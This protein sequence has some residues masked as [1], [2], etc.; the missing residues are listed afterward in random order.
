MRGVDTPADLEDFFRAAGSDYGDGLVRRRLPTPPG[1]DVFA[2]VRLP[3]GERAL[4]VVTNEQQ[5]DDSLVV[6][7]GVS[8]RIRSGNVEVVGAS[9][10]DLRLLSVLLFDLV[11]QLRSRAGSPSGIL[12]DRINA[13]R[14]MLGRGLWRGLTPQVRMGLFGELVVL[15]D[16]FLP[17]LGKQAVVAWCGPLGR[18]KDFVL[19]GVGVEVKTVSPGTGTM[20]RI[21]NE[22]QLD[23]VD[24]LGVHLLHQ[25]VD[26]GATGETLVD[27]VDGLRSDPRLLAVRDEFEDRLLEAGWVEEDRRFHEEDRYSLIERTCYHVGEGFPRLL[28]EGLAPGVSGVSYRIDLMVCRPHIVSEEDVL[29]AVT[30]SVTPVK[31]Q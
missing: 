6:T 28:P 14:R 7:A 30:A 10:T 8:C 11:T 20:C 13:W 12:V 24:L 25:T 16:L 2:E 4:L 3:E 22:H 5:P 17:L 26:R 1:I 9:G 21:N 29:S 31:E 18:P 23:G 15:R 27:L 19:N